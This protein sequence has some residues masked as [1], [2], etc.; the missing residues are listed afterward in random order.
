VYNAWVRDVLIRQH[1]PAEEAGPSQQQPPG[2]LIHL[3]TIY[4]GS[5]PLGGVAVDSEEH[6]AQIKETTVIVKDEIERLKIV[7]EEKKKAKLERSNVALSPELMALLQK[8]PIPA[9]KDLSHA[10]PAAATRAIAAQH[11]RAIPAMAAA[12]G[13][14]LPPFASAAG[15]TQRRTNINSANAYLSS[16][17]PH[18]L[19]T[20]RNMHA[21]V[22]QHQQ[23][24]QPQQQFQRSD[25]AQRLL[26]HLEL[27]AAQYNN[28]VH[29][30]SFTA[31]RPSQSAELP[32]PSPQ[33]PTHIRP[34]QQQ[35][36]QQH[37]N[38]QQLDLINS[39]SE[40]AN[41][42]FGTFPASHRP[43]QQHYQQYD[44]QHVLPSTN[45][46]EA[47]GEQPDESANFAAMLLNMMA[48]QQDGGGNGEMD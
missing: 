23:Q 11:Q 47:A 21:R 24:Q 40:H 15:T 27:R 43:Q 45:Q 17:R 20:Q 37:F 2:S 34:Q 14:V 8:R 9:P 13:G 32:P 18:P 36:Q 41:I 44:Q 31:V 6:V 29:N 3:S 4:P 7:L 19:P 5:E 35:Q 48:K 1:P 46:V 10:Q 16:S 26:Q 39:L 42:Q 12:A 33:R 30:G 22:G 28:P 38:Q 25:L